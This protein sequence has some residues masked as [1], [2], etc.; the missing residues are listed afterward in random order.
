MKAELVVN[1]LLQCVKIMQLKLY[2][3][4]SRQVVQLEPNTARLSLLSA[5]T[6]D[7]Q[8]VN[9][10]AVE[11]TAGVGCESIEVAIV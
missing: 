10:L 11:D 3:D 7:G 2:G 8:R 5:S 9:Q 4:V 1:G 6:L